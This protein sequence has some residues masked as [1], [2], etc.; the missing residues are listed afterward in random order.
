MYSL[1]L[2]KCTRKNW[3]NVLART[4]EI[5]SPELRKYTR[6]NWENVLDRTGENVPARTEKMYSPELGKWTRQNWG[7]CTRQQQT[8]PQLNKIYNGFG[9]IVFVRYRIHTY[10]KVGN[11]KLWEK[12]SGEEDR[13]LI[14]RTLSTV[15]G[16]AIC[17]LN[18]TVVFESRLSELSLSLI[19][20]SEPTRR[21]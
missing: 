9:R 21:A 13:P 8:W 15:N 5:Y 7:K 18:S 3:E 4:G 12:R 17:T 2:R 16:V 11:A 14:K 20:I 19:H 1:E 10:A 6:Q